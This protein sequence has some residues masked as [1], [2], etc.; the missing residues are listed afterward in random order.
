MIS[1]LVVRAII[2]T[3]VWITI[4]RLTSV[5]RYVHQVC[6]LLLA[7]SAAVSSSG[8]SRSARFLI[9]CGIFKRIAAITAGIKRISTL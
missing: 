3:P 5:G 1:D 4:T 8:F 2:H 9:G 6:L 7:H